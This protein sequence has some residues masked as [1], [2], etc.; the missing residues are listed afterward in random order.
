VN[1]SPEALLD[2]ACRTAWG[3]ADILLEHYAQP[4]EVRQKFDGPVTAADLASDRYILEQLQEHCGTEQFAYLSEETLGG[5]ERFE[6][7]FVWVIDPLD[8]TRDFIDR[9][10]EFAVHIALVKGSEPLLAAVAWPVRDRVYAARAGGGAFVLDRGGTRTPLRVSGR[11]ELEHCRV[12]VSRTHRDWRLDAL[13][14]RLP[15]AEQIVRGGLGCKLCSIAAGEAEVYI[16]LSGKSAPCE[17][18]LAA[19][20]IVLTDAGGAVSRFDGEPLVYNREDTHLWGGLIASN[21][22]TH[23]RLCALLPVLLEQVERSQS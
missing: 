2:L 21:G 4:V 17:W 6:R 8:G 20:Q 14:A 22:F 19:P 1:L 12:I 7:P 10:G 16:G 5:C 11:R 3:A 13:L 15:K 18:D 23:H 9:T